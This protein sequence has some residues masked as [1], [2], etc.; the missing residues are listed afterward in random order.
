MRACAEAY[1]DA[2]TLR[3][4]GSPPMA[5]FSDP[6]AIKQVFAGDPERLRAGEAQKVIFKPF[7]GPN[8]ILVLD[9]ARHKSERKL[10][11]PPFHS[12]RVRLYGNIMCEIADRS[13]D[14]WPTGTSFPIHS[15]LQEISLDII[16]RI[17]FG[18]DDAAL[19]S[20]LRALLVRW[21][22][23]NWG[24]LTAWKR[25]TQFR[26]D[27]LL[28]DEIARRKKSRREE[29]TDIMSMLVAARYEDGRYMSDEEIRDELMTVLIAG[30]ETTATSMAWVV[31]HL[32]RNPD[33]LATVQAEVES[34]SGYAPTSKLTAEQVTELGYL[35]AVIRETARINPVV[36]IV[37]RFLETDMRIGDYELPAG[38]VATPCI[39][40]THRRPE[41]WSEPESFNPDRFVG[42][43]VA[44]YTFF[45]FG[46]GVRRCLGAALATYEMKIVLA[47]LLSRVT[48]RSDPRHTVQVVRRGITFAPSG[49]MPVIRGAN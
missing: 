25:I 24:A 35:D 13:I 14:A 46:G 4:V 3:L 37:V 38:S 26:I 31:H 23:F 49:G 1:G 21:L 16:L 2:F 20:R 9:S 7:V 33:V 8:S 41:L 39:Y 18:L 48:L 10:L 32:L 12:E 36:P 34:V 45:P 22:N 42:R 19:L 43:Q 40:L 27:R 6:E 30:H 15:R 28:Y 29:Q 5:F 17:V 47:R 44:P 11:M